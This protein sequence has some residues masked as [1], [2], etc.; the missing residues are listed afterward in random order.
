MTQPSAPFPDRALKD[1]LARFAAAR[2]RSLAPEGGGEGDGGAAREGENARSFVFVDAFAGA[3]LQFGS[4]VAREEGEETRAAAVLRALMDA[5]FDPP[6]GA[7]LVEED[8]A[9]LQRI[10]ADLERIDAS[11][12][13]RGTGAFATLEPG[14]IALA[15]GTA[16]ALAE[17][18]AA[19]ASGAD[20]A[21]VL[22]AP[23]TARQM[24]WAVLHAFARAGRGVDVLVRLPH[25]DFEKQAR[26][27]VPVAD[28]PP[29]AKRIVEGCSSM[30]D[31][32]RHEWLPAW[33][34]AQREGGMERALAAVLERFHALLE[35]AAPGRTVRP[36]RLALSRR[37]GPSTHLVLLTAEARAVADLDAAIAAAGLID[38]G[39]DPASDPKPAPKTK[40]GGKPDPAPEPKSAP[41]SKSAPA[42][43][44]ASA[45]TSAST[46]TFASASTLEPDLQSTP[47]PRSDPDPQPV[48]KSKSGK[49]GGRSKSRTASKA[50]RAEA[51]DSPDA[52]EATESAESID[53]TAD[54]VDSVEATAS[55]G[56]MDDAEPP[57]MFESADGFEP[58]GSPDAVDGVAPAASADAAEAPGT[59]ASPEAAEVL[60]LFADA[61]PLPASPA[62]RRSSPAD[63]AKT[64]AKRERKKAAEDEVVGFFFDEE[65]LEP[66]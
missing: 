52:I 12:R 49:A 59:A 21:L 46:P 36:V 31:D 44:S 19:W 20:R 37:D 4:G 8:P 55:A 63:P 7:A 22:L 47:E 29:F 28:L 45:S 3:E 53:Q 30:L 66:E 40:P 62:P 38:L 11:D 50:S 65:S 34:A 10:Y 39:A 27:A 32:A 48:S 16:A 42:P 25:T 5:S 23:A 17:A 2:A 60:D 58:M 9:H 33:R 6:A 18:A 26:F 15:E 54:S 35:R 51:V 43:K 13:V 61:L 64:A 57:A 41:P 1:A 56:V 14:E 24:P